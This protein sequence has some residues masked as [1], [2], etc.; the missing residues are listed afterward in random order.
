[1]NAIRFGPFKYKTV[2]KVENKSSYIESYSRVLSAA[3]EELE[4]F[5]ITTIPVCY[6]IV[7]GC[8]IRAFDLRI[9]EHMSRQLRAT[10]QSLE[11][12][13]QIS[14][15]TEWKSSLANEETFLNLFRLSIEIKKQI[16]H[17]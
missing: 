12:A 10:K 6:S 5:R 3:R 15:V 4:K 9:V 1:M 14:F 13:G 8:S 11:T 2:T 7:K 17:I 16:A